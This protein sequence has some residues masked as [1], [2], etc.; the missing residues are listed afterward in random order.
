MA[1]RGLAIPCVGRLHEYGAFACPVVVG[2]TRVGPAE[3]E[4]PDLCALGVGDL[5]AGVRRGPP[6]VKILLLADCLEPGYRL[7]N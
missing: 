5:A 6:G 1:F 3:S 2:G 7:Q 4:G